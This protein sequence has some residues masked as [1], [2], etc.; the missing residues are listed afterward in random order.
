MFKK[1]IKRALFSLISAYLCAS[2]FGCGIETYQQVSTLA[3]PLGLTAVETN[4]GSGNII[5]LQFWGLNNE[6]FFSGYYIYMAETPNDL[7]IGNG[8][9]LLNTQGQVGRPTIY[10]IPPMT[11]A[12]QFSYTVTYY[13]NYTPL[14]SGST[15]FFFVKAYSYEYNIYSDPCNVTNVTF[16]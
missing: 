13:T 5:F 6:P 12:Q 4:F 1:M 14:Q 2:Y 10:N 16:Y 15:Y 9:P 3:S 11:S 7:F 8:M